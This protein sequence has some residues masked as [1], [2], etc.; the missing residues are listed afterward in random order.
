MDFP[1]I[2]FVFHAVAFGA[3]VFVPFC[4]SYAQGVSPVQEIETAKGLAAESRAGLPDAPVPAKDVAPA[5]AV[6]VASSAGQEGA[7]KIEDENLFFD[8]EAGAHKGAGGGKGAPKKVSPVSSP[9]SVLSIVTRD[10][11]P[12]SKE[13]RLVA[14]DRAM[15]LG[16]TEAALEIYDALYLKNKR[17][18][19]ILLGRALA[20][21]SL[22]QDDNAIETYQALLAIQPKNLDAQINMN[23][24]IGKRYPAVALQKLKVLYEDNP[25]N[26][27]VVAQMAFLE[28]KLGHYREAIT[29]LETAASAEPENASL[30]FN[31]GVIADRSG[32]KKTAIKY[33]ED[34]LD[35]DTLYGAGNSIPRDTVFERLAQLR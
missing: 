6:P 2:R 10:S 21:Q 33:Y 28:A 11:S 1:L 24:L 23:G 5:T 9:S 12:D 22:G 4:G 27:A 13:A 35:V 32:D 20:Q 26:T 30:V 29:L 15:K 17:D 3:A 18:P 25:G 34:A 8:A 31:M 19:N 7:G 14:A 16:R